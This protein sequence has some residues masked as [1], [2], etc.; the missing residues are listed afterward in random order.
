[1]CGLGEGDCGQDWECEGP[2]VCIE[3]L[4]LCRFSEIFTQLVD[5]VVDYFL[6]L[7]ACSQGVRREQL[8]GRVQQQRGR[9]T[10]A[11]GRG[12]R[13]L[14]QVTKPLFPGSEMALI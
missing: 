10:R 2:L 1:M 8:P 4:I 6:Q 14:H 13:L 5:L 9:R 7:L 12:G 11:L 3:P